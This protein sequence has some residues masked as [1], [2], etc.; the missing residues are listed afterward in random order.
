MSGNQGD[1]QLYCLPGSKAEGR[2]RPF[3]ATDHV[4]VHVP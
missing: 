1:A 3:I 2:Q 4:K